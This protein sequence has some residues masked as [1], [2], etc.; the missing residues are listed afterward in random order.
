MTI[1]VNDRDPY[2]YSAWFQTAAVQDMNPN[3]FNDHL[4]LIK[5]SATGVTVYFPAGQLVVRSVVKRLTRLCN[6]YA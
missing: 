1:L 4:R 6:K 2:G 5:S 3:V